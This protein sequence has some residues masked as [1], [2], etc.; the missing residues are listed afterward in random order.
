MHAMVFRTL[1]A[2]SCESEGANTTYITRLSHKKEAL[3]KSR[4]LA[5]SVL[6][7]FRA[8]PT[9]GLAI[10]CHVCHSEGMCHAFLVC[11]AA[12]HNHVHAVYVV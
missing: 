2:H 12:R 9:S 6:K 10:T 4:D 1:K 11:K 7:T 3:Y 8:E 5:S